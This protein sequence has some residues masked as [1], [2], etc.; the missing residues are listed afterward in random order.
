MVM[1]EISPRPLSTILTVSP[2]PDPLVV[3]DSPLAVVYPVP[4]G[5][6]AL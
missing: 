1:D 6:D 5:F 4:V 2:I 3:V